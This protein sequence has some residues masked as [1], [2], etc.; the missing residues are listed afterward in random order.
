MA[1]QKKQ[2]IDPIQQESMHEKIELQTGSVEDSAVHS[3]HSIEGFEDGDVFE[4]DVKA[5][6]FHPDPC[7]MCITDRPKNT[8]YSRVYGRD[9]NVR[10]IKCHF[11]KHRYKQTG[12]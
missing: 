7:P 3:D 4:D 9:G 5:R 2:L 12:S 1:K 8:N 11:C 10:Y 6:R